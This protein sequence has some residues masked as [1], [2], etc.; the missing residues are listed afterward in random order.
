MIIYFLNVSY[1]E[2]NEDVVINQFLNFFFFFG[3]PN[4]PKYLLVVLANVTIGSSH[5]N[6]LFSGDSSVNDL[7]KSV[8]CT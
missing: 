5:V 3:S 4:R 7:L 1:A 8:Q 6:R 2:L